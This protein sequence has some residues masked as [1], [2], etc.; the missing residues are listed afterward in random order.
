MSN[1][2]ANWTPAPRPEWVQRLNEEGACMNISGVVPLDEESLLS[3]AQR[4]T[5]LSD[6]GR[7][8]WREPFRIFIR[9]LEEESELN[10]MG[11][12]RTRSEILQL[13]EAR[14][15]I[16]DAYRRHPEI[17]DERI[18]K[19]IIV[20]GQ[21]RSGTSFLLNLLSEDPDNGVIRIWETI[22]PCPPPEK[23]TYLT[24]PRIERA[25]QAITQWNRVTPEFATM[26]EFGGAIPAECSPVIAMNFM[27]I[28]WLACFG[29]VPA[30]ESYM[31]AQPVEPALRYHQRVLKLLQWKNPRRRWVLKDPMH[32]DRLEALLKLYP[33]A[34][35]VWP[36]RDP[37]KALASVVSSMGTVQWGRS[38]HPF[39]NNS[40]DIGLDPDIVGARFNAIIDKIESG[41]VPKDRLFNVLYRDLIDDPIGTIAALYRYFDIEF[42]GKAREAI[43]AYCERNPRG[44]R[45]THRVGSAAQEDVEYERRALRRYQDYFGIPDE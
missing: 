33:D 18:E 21:G 11:R 10:L 15:Q 32:L 37:V 42:T 22:Y 8:D 20:V 4:A 7:D 39:K 3:A 31:A 17:A 38:D 28:S 45:A 24:D 9:S 14:L 25:H 13:L 23:A 27:S 26:H 12:I 2:R 34:C 19:P 16:E 35:F 29:Q 44:A 6:F 1:R 30:Y 5:G 36:H 41:D 40:L 43:A